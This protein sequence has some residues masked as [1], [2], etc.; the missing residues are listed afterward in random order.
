MF[1]DKK[2]KGYKV[3]LNSC[4]GGFSLSE[5]A[6][7]MLNVEHDLDIDREYGYLGNEDLG[8]D[9]EN[10]EAYRMDKRLVGVVEK[11][12]VDKASGKHASL[13]IVN[14]PDEVVEV[15]GWHVDDYDGCESVHQ[16]HWV[17]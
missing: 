8:I 17:G 10:F 2:I 5:E 6:I 16:S 7:E 4:F 3:V 12:G 9:D 13:R 11:L 14:V 15:Y 1:D